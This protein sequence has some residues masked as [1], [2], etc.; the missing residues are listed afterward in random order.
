MI[1]GTR[2]IISAAEVDQAVA[3]QA[4]RL[5]RDFETREPQV[6]VVMN[7]GFYYAAALTRHWDFPMTVDYAHATRYRGAT[8]GS[9]LRWVR[10]LPEKSVQGR[11]VVLLDDIFDEG[12]TLAAIA[13]SCEADGAA[14]VTTAVLVRK[15][16]D[17]G[18]PRDWIDDAALDVPD[19]YVFGCGMDYKERW[20]Q[21]PGIWEVET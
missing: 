9:D 19:R 1:E 2:E 8:R 12:H 5:A 16:H 17:R 13:E 7:G 20:R 15:L 14:S 21:L 6:V 18:L 4:D 10:P 3:Q 11:H